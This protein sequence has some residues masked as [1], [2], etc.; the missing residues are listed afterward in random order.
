MMTFDLKAELVMLYAMALRWNCT[1]QNGI[2]IFSIVNDNDRLVAI[3]T[4]RAGYLHWS[5]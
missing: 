2:G 5:T 1:P 3:Q 4:I